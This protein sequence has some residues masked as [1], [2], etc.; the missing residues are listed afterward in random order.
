MPWMR[1]T[2]WWLVGVGLAT[3]T[4][5]PGAAHGQTVRAEGS[6]VRAGGNVQFVVEVPAD[7]QVDGITVD[8][9]GHGLDT[10]VRRLGRWYGECPSGRTCFFD[11]YHIVDERTTVGEHTVPFIATGGG[12]THAFTGR[13]RVEPFADDDHDGMP[14][15]W[16]HREG[17]EPNGRLATSAPGDDPDGDL[18]GNIDE[19]RAGTSPIGRYRQYFGDASPGDRQQMYPRLAGLAAIRDT[20][21]YDERVRVRVVGDDGRQVFVFGPTDLD[22]GLALFD[23]APN[24]SPAARV[25]A[26]E[27]ESPKPVVVEQRLESAATGTLSTNRSVTPST[28]WMFTTGP[29]S[30]PVDAFLLAY[31]PAPTPVRAT[32]TYYRSADEAPVVTERVLQPG[33]TTVWINADESALA[34]RDFA[35][36]IHAEGD[37]IVNRGFRWQPPGRTAPQEHVSPG[38]SLATQWYFPYVNASRQSDEQLV[39]ANPADRESGVEVAIFR[40]EGEPRVRYT[41][42][43]AHARLTLRPADFDLDTLAAVRFATT[44][45]VPF[46]AEHMQRGSVPGRGRWA[47]ITPGVSA[48]GT[49]WGLPLHGGHLV[50]W[51]P[52]DTDAVVDVTA[53]Y[54]G[55]YLG[56]IETT[57]RIPARRVSRVPMNPDPNTVQPG[58]T[59]I[60]GSTAAVVS[61]ARADGTPGPAIVVGRATAAGAL[62]TRNVR[63]EPFIATRVD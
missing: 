52:S 15:T 49:R 27:I 2:R 60:S 16:E 50:V 48:T 30:E 22:Y 59:V 32:F 47:S 26:I 17:L 40:R 1:S 19:F 57:L 58:E 56:T 61:R 55:H 25:L 24:I 46:V 9:I 39:L 42:I 13:F 3:S 23:W 51:N 54:P 18:V 7:W 37:V 45:G 53:Y 11:G 33:R 4:V 10:F 38:A 29:T 28:D 36:A 5:L 43:P 6:P 31:N 8:P 21:T 34:G 62:G 44:N 20:L 14:D 63:I 12:Q 41:T 35:V